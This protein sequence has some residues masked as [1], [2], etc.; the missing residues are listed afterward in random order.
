MLTPALSRRRSRGSFLRALIAAIL[1]RAAMRR[2]R[3]SLAL[4]DD[5]LLCDIGLTRTEAAAA[6]AR[7][8]W[9]APLHWKA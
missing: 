2:S 9:S 8:D 1:H 3:R 4:L 7:S 5:H 6:A